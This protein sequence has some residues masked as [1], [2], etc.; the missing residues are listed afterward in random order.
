MRFHPNSELIV[1]ASL[2][3]TARIWDRVTGHTVAVIR[4]SSR[5]APTQPA[6]PKSASFSAD[7]SELLLA[8]DTLDRY[9]CEVCGA[10]P[11]L[12]TLARRRVTRNLTVAE[13]AAYLHQTS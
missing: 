5:T 9:R 3:R 12:V 6:E 7:G 4:P 2:D 8:S 11:T 1:T 13:R 10:L